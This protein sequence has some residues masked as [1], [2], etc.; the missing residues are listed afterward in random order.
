MRVCGMLVTK[1]LLIV[2]SARAAPGVMP[3]SDTV[4]FC[5]SQMK[6]G[7][8][9]D[10][11]RRWVDR[12]LLIDP[13]LNDP[14]VPR[15]YSMV[16][17]SFEKMLRVGASYEMDGFAFFPETSGRVGAYEYIDRAAP[18]G[19]SL[20]TEFLARA[21]PAAKLKVL[22]AALACEHSFRRKGK[23]L[24]TSYRADSLPAEEW[25]K[26]LAT[27]R[28]EVGDVFLFLPAISFPCGEGWAAWMDRFDSEQGV[29]VADRE[30]LKAYLRSYAEI[31][32]GVYL[33]S[34][35]AIKRE[36][37]MHARFYRE[38]LAPLFREVID[39]PAMKAKGKL[40]GLSA[41]L[42]HI[43]STRLG[44]TLGDDGTRT[45]RDSLEAAMS[46]KPDVLVIPEWDE[47]NEN[48]S[49]RP[50]VDNGYTSKRIMRYYM[51]CIKGRK[52]TP[53]PGDDTSLPNLI[54]SYRKCVTLGEELRFELLNVPDSETTTTYRAQLVLRGEAGDLAQRFPWRSFRA[55]RLME[56]T[57]TLAS[58]DVATRAVLVP[59]LVIQGSDGVERTV[60]DGWRA[61]RL[62]ATAN[63]DY[64]WVKQGLRDIGPV[65]AR[66]RIR[67]APGNALTVEGTM[68]CEEPI[69]SVELVENGAVIYAVNKDPQALRERQDVVM[70]AVEC[71]AQRRLNVSGTIEILNGACIW[72]ESYRTPQYAWRLEEGRVKLIRNVGAPARTVYLAVP[73]TDV[74]KARLRCEVN[75]FERTIPVADLLA[76]RIVTWNDGAGLSITAS[77]STKQNIHPRHLGT[78]KAR[79]MAQVVP[80]LPTSVFHLR[81]I[82][83]SGRIWRGKPLTVRPTKAE[84]GT[85]E[86]PIWSETQGR[87]VS[88]RV[89]ARRVPDIV[90]PLDGRHGGALVTTAG[91]PFWGI[92]GG[93]VDSVTGRGG[94]VGGDGSPFIRASTYPAKATRAA[95]EW[96]VEDGR[97]C[98]RFDG[99]GTFIALPQG[100]LPRRGAFHLSFE[101]K[102]RV[103]KEQV[104]FVHRR[105]YIGSLAVRLTATGQLQGRFTTDAIK[106]YVFG[107]GIS[108][109]AGEWSKVEIIYN[110][111]EMRVRVNGRESGPFPCRG[112]G[113]YDMCSVFGGFGGGGEVDSFTG[114]S[115][116]FDGWLSSLRVRHLAPVPRD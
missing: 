19:F 108:V 113:L 52:Q 97:S 57:E 88:V 76:R 2:G 67:P 36:R 33:A 72:P 45:L 95:P 79:F 109:P 105:H 5:R 103:A 56:F 114:T 32:D 46:V 12:P 38:F 92:L 94:A 3:P 8:E 40:L 55:D 84:E 70:L 6:Y 50:T 31:G 82:T 53:L 107:D 65:R 85:V 34:A 26:L 74:E 30:K 80:D 10:Y 7:L 9:R 14:A 111:A 71:R 16:Y 41:C 28:A 116:W 24:V 86:L 39:E 58:E 44:Y 49:L 59:E 78:L 11:L 60:A 21:D 99:T 61:T 112:V 101:V 1:C 66:D 18:A 15:K 29:S 42:A 91:R 110:L 23:L 27:L 98:L 81:V 96:S 115:G 69:A 89:Q 93:Y 17:P 75:G 4:V 20:L 48:T 102:P 106:T 73:K 54:L 68:V 37:K 62:S 51:R 64:K 87:P 25:R 35:A 77:R 43:N 83:V 104:L 90:Y 63:W 47:Q 22:K 100:V 13:T